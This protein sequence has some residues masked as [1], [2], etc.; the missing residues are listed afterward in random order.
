MRFTDTT[1]AVMPKNVLEAEVRLWTN[2]LGDA[3]QAKAMVRRIATSDTFELSGEWLDNLVLDDE[4]EF[5]AWLK[6]IA[7]GPIP[8]IDDAST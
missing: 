1:G 4:A 3:D 5:D 2:V 7:G 8:R 6:A